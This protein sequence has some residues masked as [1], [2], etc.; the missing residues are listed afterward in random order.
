M[1]EFWFCDVCKS[2]NRAA[3]DVCYSC[4]AP[5]T[6]ASFASVQARA[7]G[8]VLTPGLDEEHRQAAW[9]LM[10]NNRY[11]SA[12]RLGYL[13]AALLAATIVALL[14]FPALDLAAMISRRTSD[15]QALLETG[16]WIVPVVVLGAVVIILAAVVVHS[17]F[18]GL[19]DLDVPA[20]GGGT[21]R[22][23]PLR[24][25]LWWIESAL[26][27]FRAALA[28]V[29]PPMLCLL[30]L[31]FGGVIFG[32]VSGLVWFALAYNVLGDPVTC[33]T[34]PHRLLA[35]LYAR[36]ALPDS[37][38]GRIVTW[39]AM[40]WGVARG[41]SY[42]VGAVIYLTIVLVVILS[43]FTPIGLTL[44]SEGEGPAAVS[45]GA[46][47]LLVDLV[48][49]VQIV[50]DVVSLVL[51]YQITLELVARQRIRERWVL[52]GLKLALPATPISMPVLP[53]AGP[54]VPGLAVRPEEEGERR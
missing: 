16:S 40:A 53:A 7:A 37:T 30:G 44:V 51:L 34:K 52:S 23:G 32:L 39:W 4:R 22:F 13:S 9:S 42:A 29:V 5:K 25:G 49:L 28:F 35:D 36:L 21:A 14:V 45:S 15:P 20:L 33:L 27:A 12:W 47:M 48:A 11:V 6:R 43:I 26:W 19:A 2:M 17:V 46:A 50:A 3:A 24:A 18:L 54:D 1:Q 10:A 31:A 8:A 38:D 41:I